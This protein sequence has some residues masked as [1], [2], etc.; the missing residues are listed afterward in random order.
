MRPSRALFCPSGI[1][2]SPDTTRDGKPRWPGLP[3]QFERT[4]DTFSGPIWIAEVAASSKAPSGRTTTIA[5]GLPGAARPGPRHSQR[6]V[7]TSSR[8]RS[9][10]QKAPASSWKRTELQSVN[11]LNIVVFNGPR[12]ELSAG[13]RCLGA[14]PIWP[15]STATGC[16]ISFTSDIPFSSPTGRN[17]RQEAI[18]SG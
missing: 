17:T 8:V 5:A 11:G 13:P 1:R 10:P 18:G 14:L 4:T 7:I 6:S 3:F 15:G 12:S 16:Q 9:H 2:G